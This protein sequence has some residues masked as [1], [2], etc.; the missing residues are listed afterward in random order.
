MAVRHW[1]N[2]GTKR[3]HERGLT[4]LEMLVVLGIIAVVAALAAPRV[5]QYLG[6][7]RHETA[8]VQLENINAALD[9]YRFD[10]GRYP[11]QQEGLTALIEDPGTD[12]RWRGPYLN[13]RE[14]INDPWGERYQYRIPG[15]H[16]EYDL[17]SLGAD[18]VEGGEDEN[19]D[20]TNW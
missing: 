18:G 11:T 7:A 14:G 2:D 13:K 15:R 4:L 10:L 5:L 16:G 9:L 1:R 20:V 19:E 12:P 3:K 17:Y 8:R 6:D